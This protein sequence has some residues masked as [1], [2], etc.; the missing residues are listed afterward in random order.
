MSDWK[1]SAAERRDNKQPLLEDPDKKLHSKKDKKTWC[2]GKVGKPHIPVCKSFQ[3]IKKWGKPEYKIL[4]CSVC[5]K[6]LAY[7]YGNKICK[8]NKPDWVVEE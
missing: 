8:E 2:G 1:K 7:Y 3:E 5:G 4:I 6:D